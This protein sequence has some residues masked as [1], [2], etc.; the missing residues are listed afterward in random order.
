MTKIE[1]KIRSCIKEMETACL[2]LNWEDKETYSDFLAQTFYYVR[3]ATR[4]LAKAA[5]KCSFE[6]EALHQILLQSI[7]EEKC[8]EQLAVHDLEVLGHKVDDFCE[9]PE[10]SAYYQTLY[11]LLDTQGPYELLGYFVT[12]EGLGAIGSD[13]LYNRVIGSHGERSSSFIKV[14]ARIDSRHF[15]E[16]LELINSL[17]SSKLEI[18][19]HGLDMGTRLYCNLIRRISN[20][21]KPQQNVA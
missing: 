6:E 12:L 1:T 14:H 17:D 13:E 20:Q 3:N 9:Y 19:E 4:V 10:T 2:E 16:G 7:N 8:H 11:H 18:V 15:E 21:A 5:F